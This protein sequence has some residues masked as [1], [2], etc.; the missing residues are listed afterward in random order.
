ME[1]CN[2]EHNKIADE[3]LPGNPCRHCGACCVVYRISFYWAEGD[4]AAEGGVPVHL[5][6]RINAFRVAMRRTGES[7]LRCAALHGVP[8]QN[9]WCS[10]YEQRPSVCRN[11]EPSWEAGKDNPLC[12][13]ART[14]LGLE[15][16]RQHS[17]DSPE[18]L[19]GPCD[20]IDIP[21]SGIIRDATPACK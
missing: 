19:K 21:G 8:G 17:G 16:H 5:T 18:Y 9:V 1:K 13:K 14:M 4:D 6:E 2:Q 7:I 11:F 3:V 20:L 15:P 10:I 12:D